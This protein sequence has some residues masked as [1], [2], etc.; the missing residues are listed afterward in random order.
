MPN[1]VGTSW[2]PFD[3]AADTTGSQA[4]QQTNVRK[5]KWNV[6]RGTSESDSKV[7][8]TDL[9]FCTKGS[10][11]PLSAQSIARLRSLQNWGKSLSTGEGALQSSSKQALTQTSQKFTFRLQ[12]RC[13]WVLSH[14][15]VHGRKV[16]KA[17]GHPALRRKGVSC[18]LDYCSLHNWWTLE[19]LS[20]PY[21]FEQVEL[22]RADRSKSLGYLLRL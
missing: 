14:R 2:V 16:Q 3:A 9:G 6:R 7:A 11:W 10:S 13:Y 22:W 17:S 12:A 1:K 8:K 19:F 5:Q 21:L 4:K 15:T 20:G 18:Y